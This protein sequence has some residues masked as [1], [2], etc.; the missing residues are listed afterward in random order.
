MIINR[1]TSSSNPSTIFTNLTR[2]THKYQIWQEV[3]STHRLL[4]IHSNST[5]QRTN[6]CRH[7]STTHKLARTR[8]P[9]LPYSQVCTKTSSKLQSVPICHRLSSNSSRR[10]LL[11]IRHHSSLLTSFIFKRRILL[12]QQACRRMTLHQPTARPQLARTDRA[13]ATPHTQHTPESFQP[14]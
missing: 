1:V 8:P 11:P 4:P 5:T 7:T 14:T 6:Q 12:R 9:T 2:T 3:H 10:F 13:T